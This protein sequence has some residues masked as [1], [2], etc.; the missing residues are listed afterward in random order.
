MLVAILETDPEPGVRM[1]AAATLGKLGGLSA[2]PALEKA[3]FMDKSALS[4]YAIIRAL[5]RL[6]K[7]KHK[8]G[9]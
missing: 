9:D 2:I 4:K 8:R 5:N 7:L 6:L 1:W 3:R